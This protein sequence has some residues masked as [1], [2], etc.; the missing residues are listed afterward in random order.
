MNNTSLIKR[1]LVGVVLFVAALFGFDL[2]QSLVEDTIELGSQNL[3]G[4][5]DQSAESNLQVEQWYEV[6]QVIDGDTIDVRVDGKDERVRLIGIDTPETQY[7]PQGEECY[8]AEASDFARTLLSD[9]SVQLVPDSTQAKRDVNG[10][11]LAYVT[12]EDGQDVGE[13][14]IV[15]GYAREYTYAE[16]Y[17]KQAAYRAGEATAQLEKKGM[18]GACES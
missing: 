13:F 17:G 1:I 11:I 18:W 16:A 2:P 6:T 10:R 12:M 9:T 15:E 7:A 8:G 5:Q 3:P 4:S 14:L